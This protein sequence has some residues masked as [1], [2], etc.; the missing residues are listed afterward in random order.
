MTRHMMSSGFGMIRSTA[1]TPRALG[2]EGPQHAAEQPAAS[3]AVEAPGVEE[4]PGRRTAQAQRA[5]CGTGRAQKAA[6]EEREA[7]TT[8]AER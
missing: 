4:P 2:Q 7:Q 1:K 3:V 8:P 6:R 5:A